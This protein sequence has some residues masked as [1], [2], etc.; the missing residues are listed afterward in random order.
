MMQP[1]RF[2]TVCGITKPGA[3][4]LTYNEA[5][6]FYSAVSEMSWGDRLSLNPKVRYF[7]RQPASTRIKE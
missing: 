6:D 5:R 4:D 1:A 3:A 7:A 2:S